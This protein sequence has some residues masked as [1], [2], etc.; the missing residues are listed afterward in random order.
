MARRDRVGIRPITRRGNDWMTR[1][2]LV[3]EA[4]NRLKVRS[5]LIDGES[6]HGMRL[7]EHLDHP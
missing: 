4:V 1:F 2:P 7:N 6:R 3:V 5:C